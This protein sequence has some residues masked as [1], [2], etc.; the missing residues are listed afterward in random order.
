MTAR[1]VRVIATIGVIA[2]L[3]VHADPPGGDIVD[4]ILH[5][6]QPPV[7]VPIAPPP[8]AVA[9][10]TPPAPPPAIVRPSAVAQPA[11][12]VYQPTP[13]APAP[14]AP[15]P[16]LPPVAPPSSS[17]MTGPDII[18][19]TT[20]AVPLPAPAPLGLRWRGF[21][22]GLNLGGGWTSGGSGTSCLNS[23]TNNT[24][25]CIIIPFGGLN[26][27]G[28]LGGA[29]VGYLAPIEPGNGMPPLMIGGE[30]DFQGSGISG[31][32]TAAPP[33][34]LV[35]FPPCTDC[36]YNATQSIKWFGTARVRLG[37]PFDNLLVYA[38]GGLIYGDIKTSQSITFSSGSGNYAGTTHSTRVGPTAGGGVELLVYG[39]WSARAEAL[40]Y[41]L[42]QVRNA[43]LPLGKAAVNFSDVKTF[44]FR[45]GI[46]RLG[47]NV[48]LGD[49]IF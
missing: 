18:G 3:P 49:L 13:F 20:A 37:I 24:S 21:Y 12:V 33:L 46:I 45:G 10:P 8:P 19:Q 48:Q 26:T 1:T 4:Q 29:Q 31:S 7:A 40:Y 2:S 23:I 42:G 5:P 32:Q 11:V 43:A 17:A 22:T 39:P 34:P 30:T 41:D 16:P 15:P 9:Y 47:V 35:G 36:A 14:P 44:G 27:H 38:T 28:V 6:N 25:G